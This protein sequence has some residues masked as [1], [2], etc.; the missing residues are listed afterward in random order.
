MGFFKKQFLDIIQWLDDSDNTLVYM[1]PMEDQEIQNGAQ[2]TV[3]QG[4]VAIFVDKGEI[5]DVFGPGMY[6]ITTENLPILSNLQHWAYGFKSP[7]KADVYFLNMKE[8]LD[9]K[10]GTSNPIWIPDTQFGQV[11]VRAHGTYAFKMK[12]PVN[13]LRNIVGTK[14]KYRLEDITSQLRGFIVSQFSNII[15]NLSLSVT[16]IAASYNEIG[17][18]LKETLT[19]PFENLGLSITHLTISNIGL[20]EEIEKHLKELTGMNI[21]GSIQSDKLSKIQILKQLSAMEKA[22][23]NSSMNSMMQA[24]M[25]MEMGMQMAK[26]YT[27]S[28]TQ[29]AQPNMAQT[30]S[31]KMQQEETCPK[32]GANI[33]KGSKFCSECGAKIERPKKKFCIQCGAAVSENMKFCSECGAK[34]R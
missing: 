25:G 13:F 14:S 7:F 3:R 15:G 22:A 2:L 17:G 19:V 32:C 11:Q 23:G 34:L 31:N 18:A 10:W 6:T 26:A 27:Q 8:Y 12:D 28:Y 30:T 1:V 9:N 24:G 29:Q 16:Q 20:P 4:Q 33:K 21:M 5:A